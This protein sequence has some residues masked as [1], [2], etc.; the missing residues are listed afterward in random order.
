MFRERRCVCNV[1]WDTHSP[2]TLWS[3]GFLSRNSRISIK[4]WMYLIKEPERK[5]VHPCKCVSLNQLTGAETAGFM[6]VTFS[7]IFG[8]KRFLTQRE[9]DPPEN[10]LVWPDGKVGWSSAAAGRPSP[11]LQNVCVCVCTSV[12]QW[13]DKQ[14][15]QRAWPAAAANAS[16]LLASLL[17][18][19]AVWFFPEFLPA[20]H[21]LHRRCGQ[22]LIWQQVDFLH[23]VWQPDGQLLPQEDKRRLL[24]GVDGTWVVGK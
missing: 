16:A 4:L 7:G 22:Q 15:T 5:A 14:L 3:S 13:E 21:H 9:V 12:S 6:S 19:S 10:T 11:L 23:D 18:C 2:R 17:K 1:M 8:S 24:A 20:L